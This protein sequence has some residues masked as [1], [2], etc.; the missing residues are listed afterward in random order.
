MKDSSANLIATDLELDAFLAAFEAAA[1]RGAEP[2]LADYLPAID[3]SKYIAVLCEL[4]R[5]DMEFRQ[6]R[7]EVHRLAEYAA[8]FPQLLED[9]TALAEIAREENRLRPSSNDAREPSASKRSLDRSTADRRAFVESVLP[10]GKPDAFWNGDRFPRPGAVLP[11]G[12]RVLDELGRGSFSRVYLA[13]QVDLAGRLVAVKVSAKLLGE[14]QTL[15]RLQ[16]A[17]IVPIYSAHR[18]GTY[19]VVVMPYLGATT[20][21]DLL[22]LVR[23]G[24][25]VPANDRT[26]ACT[27]AALSDPNDAA[28]RT[29]SER[30]LPVSLPDWWSKTGFADAVLKL[31]I[32]LAT[33]LSHAHGRGISHRDLK[34]ANVLLTDDGRPMLLDFNLA[35]DAAAETDRSIG[36]TPRYMAPEQLTALLGG[37]TPV[38]ER[39]DIYSLG[40]IVHELLTGD[41]PFA[42]N[43][44]SWQESA[45][46]SLADRLDPGAIRI[47]SPAIASIVRKCLQPHPRDRYAS[48]E[49]LRID[50]ER[51]LDHRPLKYAAE[52]YSRERLRKWT[53]RH[54]RLSSSTTAAI[55]A[56][57][58]V[59]AIAGIAFSARRESQT[60]EAKLAFRSTVD[61]LERIQP[62]VVDRSAPT[63]QF[64]EARNLAQVALAIYG[65]PEAEN[66]RDSKANRMLSDADRAALEKNVGQLLFFGAEAAA[67]VAA[68]EFDPD[69]R[70]DLQSNA[71]LWKKRAADELQSDRDEPSW[72]A[73]AMEDLRSKRYRAVAER[74]REKVAAGER[75]YSLWMALGAAC[76]HLHEPQRAADAFQ[77]ACALEPGS[78]WA[79]YHRGVALLEAERFLAA[80]ESFDRFVDIRPDEPDGRINRAL[81][82]LRMGQPKACLADLDEAAR[83]GG[84][85]PR[86]H[87]LR[88]LAWIQIGDERKAL[89]ARTLAL[90][91]TPTDADG[92]T[93]R[94]E[95][96]S[97]SSP[98]DVAG[99]LAA[100]DAALEF[101]AD[102]IP[103][104]RG[105]AS[106]LSERLGK[107]ES[108]IVLYERILMLDSEAADD[109]A[110]Y[111]VLLARLGKR[112]DARRAARACVERRP[113]ALVQ[114]QA[115]S[116]LALTAESP[117]ER[118]EAI[119]ALRVAL[120]LDTSWA[121]TMSTDTDLQSVSDDP[122]FQEIIRAAEKL[123][124]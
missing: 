26:L 55:L 31:A 33:G 36:G 44:G 16:H 85:G 99:A 43:G 100:F 111:A 94:G 22:A 122:R 37:S 48:A 70:R 93:I 23:S 120:K 83:K 1:W 39:A 118:T 54:P 71:S 28:A 74:L 92:W 68:R 9:R 52:R 101:D 104:L 42:E 47:E 53:L 115:A 7:G 73:T 51:H 124:K 17:N 46:S 98:A 78:P 34:P 117:S 62:L 110:A 41:I 108:A 6:S 21:A 79:F 86:A 24:A 27:V 114:Y 88:E 8:R 60:L 45:A 30:T 13:E 58:A 63:D 19:Q 119:E 112:E 38:D 81:A 116:A 66:W 97:R 82:Y 121:A 40:L 10:F 35:A 103:A 25:T 91:A 64:R 84:I 57:A 107:P 106:L 75:S 90:A 5:V 2:D 14:A 4:V 72:Y 65:L 18:V 11:P 77:A 109:R 102:H 87:S 15:A 3:H 76:L 95:I 67:E 80:K 61:S 59:A 32:D 113:R 89:E 96:R 123:N 12:F 20:L 29:A 56:F 49:A 50:L 105:K 69:R